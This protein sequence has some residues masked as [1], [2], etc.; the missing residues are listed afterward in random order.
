M[1]EREVTFKDLGLI[2]ELCEAC[3]KMKW[4]KPTQIQKEAIP[5]A[6]QGKDVVGIAE[7]GSGK[8]GAFGLPILQA[9]LLKPQRMFALI[10]TPTRELAIQIKEQLDDLGREFGLSCL[11]VVGGIDMTQQ[12]LMLLKN[13]HIIVATLGRIVDHLKHLKGFSLSSIKYLVMDEADR[14]LNLDFE[15][16]VDRVVRALP[17]QRTTMLFSATITN[18]VTIMT[19]LDIPCVDYVINLEVPSSSDDYIH[20]VGRTAR[21]GRSGVAITFVSQFEIEDFLRIEK[22]VL[23]GSDEKNMP[24]YPTEK[25]D[26]E[27]FTEKVIAAEKS[28]K[29]EMKRIEDVK[30]A[31]RG[32]NSDDDDTE[33]SKRVRKRLKKAQDEEKPKRKFV[34]RTKKTVK[35]RRK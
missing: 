33:E 27:K 15:E 35:P 12:A 16:E 22:V 17:K 8:T 7:T 14:V 9:L 31:N 13:P 19:G 1:E 25:Q 26:V 6:L 30:K 18:K 34:V 23:Q 21:A 20:R 3:E 5:V 2:D 10:L 29:S 28:A 32:E 11:A 4:T 24:V